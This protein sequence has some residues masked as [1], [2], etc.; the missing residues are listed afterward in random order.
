MSTAIL[1]PSPLDSERFGLRILRG[2]ADSLHAKTLANEIIAARADVCILRLPTAQSAPLAKLARWGF[3]LLHADTLVHYTCDLARHAPAALRNADLAFSLA[4]ADDMPALRE[5]IA[6]TFRDYASHYHAN[7][8]FARARILAGYQQW[9]EGHA[10]GAGR[11]L[12]VARRDRRIVAFAACHDDAASGDAAGILY[13]VA[14]DAAGGGLYGDLIRHTQRVARERG[15]QRMTVSTQVGNYAVQKVWAREGFHLFEALDTFHVN[16]LL[17]AGEVLVERDLVFSAAQIQ[18]FAD[19]SG[20]HNPIH[21]DADAARAAGFP[22]RIA[23]GVMAAAELSRILGTETPGPGTIIRDL[24][25]AFLRPLLADAAYRIC[26]RMVGDGNGAK[27]VVA[28]IGDAAGQP[29]VIAR[30]DILCAR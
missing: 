16:A 30:S 6:H 18:R 20:D 10:A 19:A 17:S 13:G 4:G 22:E 14:P 29:C 25:M 7:P 21:V 27:Q 12:W 3:P 11:T 15:A 2:R 28:T 5:L 9:A 1:S 23:H 8:L 26:V 24:G